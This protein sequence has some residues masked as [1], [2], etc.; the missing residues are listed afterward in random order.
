MK[1]VREEGEQDKRR[2]LIAEDDLATRQRLADT[3]DQK[4]VSRNNR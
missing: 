2:I 3:D 4:S 1:P